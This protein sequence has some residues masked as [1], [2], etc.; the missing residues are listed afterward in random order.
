MNALFFDTETTGLVRQKLAP[1]H[2]DQPMPVQL[3]MKLDAGDRSEV[4]VSNFL[5]RTDGKWIVDPKAAEITGIDNEKADAYGVDLIAAYEVFDA[6][7]GVADVIVAHNA[8]FDVTVMRR[9][10]AVY[11]E[12]TGTQYVDPFEGKKLI[13][14][15]LAS[16]PIVKAMPK[17]NGQYKWPKLEECVQHFFGRSIVGAH[18]ALVDVRATAEVF[19][20]LIDTGVFSNEARQRTSNAAR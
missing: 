15:M 2:P 5:I 6:Y 18:D 4:G 3:G 11:A 10:A 9:T 13:C 1:T 8:A 14:T 17:R 19:Y 7:V 12:I 16:T 20:H